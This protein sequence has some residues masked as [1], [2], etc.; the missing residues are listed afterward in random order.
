MVY[1]LI[2]IPRPEFFVLYN[3]EAAFPD[4]KTLKLSDAFEK[5]GSLRLPEKDALELVV[6]VVNINQGKNEALAK[7]CKTLA[8][9]SVF[10]AKVRE[11]EKECGDRTEAMKR[12]I[13]YCRDNDILKAFLE[14]NGTEVINML[15]TEWNMDDALA[16][17][18]EEGK[19]EGKEEG[20]EEV[21]RNALA[22][23]L[24]PDVICTI[25]GLDTETLKTL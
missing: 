1:G 12:A 19:E 24:S 16:V 17:R 7:K 21:A 3:G 10:I 23:G 15:L 8:G 9:Y 22:K 6:K 14:K 5:T 20:R 25:T 13:R 4:E 11:F 2:P 18:F